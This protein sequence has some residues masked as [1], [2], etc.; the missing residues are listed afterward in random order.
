[1]PV[2]SLRNKFIPFGQPNISKEEIQAVADVLSSQWI[3]TGRITRQFEEEFVRYMGGGYAIAVSSCSI[4]LT[5]ALKSIGLCHGDNVL[6]TPLTFCATVN[7]ILNAGANPIFVDVDED[8]L[9]D[10]SKIKPLILKGNTYHEI[11]CILPVNYLGKSAQI[12][13]KNIPVVEDAAHSFGGSCGYGNI[14][15]FSFY[16][17]KNISC[18]EGGM[19]WTKNK[20]LANKCRI[21]SN[22]GQSNGAW[23]RYSSGPIENYSVV[24]PG[25]KGNLPDV[26]SAI[27]LVQL[28]RWP[29][30][31]KKRDRVWKIYEDSFGVKS[32]GHSHHLYTIHVRERQKLREKLYNKG[33]GTGVHY[34]A[35]HLEPAYS[36]LGYKAGDFPNAEK[37]GRE[38]VS[39]PISNSMTEEDAEYVVECVKE[40]L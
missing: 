3:G 25:Y 8:G 14:T 38:T 28:R 22:N 29:E 35:L 11:S 40:I 26:L 19:I 16:A 21:L 7:S 32:A 36:F 6:T 9:M 17:T 5:I 1:M 30:M 37:I 20:E 15:V 12:Q 24:H 39:L 34:E 31:K 23:S 10:K 4:G 13:P 33:I 27:G 2:S 18:G